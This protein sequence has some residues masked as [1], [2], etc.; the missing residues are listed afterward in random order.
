[1]N[2]ATGMGRALIPCFM[3]RL[4]TRWSGWPSTNSMARKYSPSTRPKS[5]TWAML[6]CDSVA[7]MRAS[8]MNMEMKASSSAYSGRTFLMSTGLVTPASPTNWAR[9][10]SAMPPRPSQDTSS[11]RPKVSPAWSAMDGGA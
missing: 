8:L 4:S 6:P 11:Y 2:T 5:K 1:M 10:V 7:E 9:H 3:A